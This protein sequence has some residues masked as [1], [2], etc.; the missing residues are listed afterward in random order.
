MKLKAFDQIFT[1]LCKE[2]IVLN[3]HRK[4]YIKIIYF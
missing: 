2:I 1:Q 3:V 4:L